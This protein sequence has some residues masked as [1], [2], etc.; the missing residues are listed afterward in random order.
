VNNLPRVVMRLVRELNPRP[1]DR[2]S[3]DKPAA[4]PR[5]PV[6][7]S[8]LFQQCA[9]AEKRNLI[10]IRTKSVCGQRAV[11]CSATLDGRPDRCGCAPNKPPA[12]VVTPSPREPQLFARSASVARRDCGSQ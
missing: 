10:I 4:P 8:S 7:R 9:V 11:P 3:D 2:K 6:L 5:Q 12:A 1:I